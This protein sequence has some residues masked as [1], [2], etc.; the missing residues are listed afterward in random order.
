VRAVILPSLDRLSRDVRIAENLFH[1]FAQLG[2]EILIADMPTYNGKDRKD[3]LIRQI[4]EAIAEEN[5]KDII[6]R[7]RK[8]REERVRRGLPPGG[9][10]AYGYQRVEKQLA[11]DEAEVQ[12]VRL[13]FELG[14]REMTGAGIADVLND[15]G[16][17]RRNGKPWMQ[18]QVAAVFSRRALYR[19]GLFR[20]GEAAGQNKSLAGFGEAKPRRIL[21][22]RV[23]V[24][25]GLP[26]DVGQV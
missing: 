7:L 14:E 9:N 2:V 15:K 11:W 25:T 18:R 13:I 21:N 1:E 4:R 17:A 16:F 6:D 26:S 5:R 19:D 20:Y 23:R 8:G 22:P 12:V 24:R 10:V 3:I